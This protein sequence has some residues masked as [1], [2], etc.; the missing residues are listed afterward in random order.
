M[1]SCKAV[2]TPRVRRCPPGLL[3]LPCRLGH[4]DL[5]KPYSYLSYKIVVEHMTKAAVEGS[6]GQK[7]NW[8]G[9][10]YDIHRNKWK[11]RFHYKK[12]EQFIG[13]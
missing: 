7:T 6:S 13:R 10:T 3:C 4:A 2:G 9:V 11:V 1:I 12:K 8:L 5:I